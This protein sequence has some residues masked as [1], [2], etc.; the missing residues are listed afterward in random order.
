MA[1]WNAIGD[2]LR[3]GK[4]VAEVFVENKEHRGERRHE[5]VLAFGP[6]GTCRVPAGSSSWLRTSRVS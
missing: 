5:E 3:G 2:V 1:W 6:D 4:D